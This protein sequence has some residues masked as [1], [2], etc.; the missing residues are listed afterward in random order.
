MATARELL[1]AA[2]FT[3]TGR[4]WQ[5]AC[6][7]CDK[8][9]SRRALGLRRPFGCVAAA[10]DGCAYWARPSEPTP[11]SATLSDRLGCLRVTYLASTMER[12]DGN[13]S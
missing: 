12:N 9:S 8:I 7:E 1:G 13:R 2:L 3:G 10:N 6:T 5:V 11:P 4:L